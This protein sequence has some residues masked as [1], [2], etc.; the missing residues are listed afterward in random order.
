MKK[1][2][3]IAAIAL[4]LLLPAA[5]AAAQGN[6]ATDTLAITGLSLL[7]ASVVSF[8]TSRDQTD[9]H[10]YIGGEYVALSVSDPNTLPR[11]RLTFVN[12][13]KSGVRRGMFYAGVGL[14]VTSLLMELTRTP[15]RLEASPTAVR[16]EYRLR[17]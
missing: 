6:T 10:G 9:V 16:A 7:G 11:P 4:L 15:V 12:P 13:F 2:K 1:L 17:F 14:T 3:N 8:H 5:P